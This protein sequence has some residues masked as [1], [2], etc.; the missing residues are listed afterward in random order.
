MRDG[1]DTLDMVRERV[2]LAAGERNTGPDR[3]GYARWI[4]KV[5]ENEMLR[6]SGE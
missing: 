5:V 2:V 4:S 6:W 1:V 3:T